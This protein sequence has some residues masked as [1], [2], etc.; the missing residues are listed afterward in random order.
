M[1]FY[2]PNIQILL[3]D[4]CSLTHRMFESYSLSNRHH[5]III[6]FLTIEFTRLLLKSYSL[7]IQ[8]L[9]IDEQIIT[10][11]WCKS[12]SLMGKV[13]LIDHLRFT[14]RIGK[15]YLLMSKSL[16]GGGSISTDCRSKVLLIDGWSPTHWQLKSY[17]ASNKYQINFI[18]FSSI[19]LTHRLP[20]PYA[21]ILKKRL[22]ERPMLLTL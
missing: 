16:L 8:V 14:H 9:L 10:H 22:I 3:S 20:K 7:S 21:W 17:S 6:Q 11:R 12:Y 18:E 15:S 5:I 4:E 19:K 1:N 13:L 2:S